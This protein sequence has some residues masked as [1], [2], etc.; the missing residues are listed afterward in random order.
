M[1]R[2][3]WETLQSQ[4]IGEEKIMSYLELKELRRHIDDAITMTYGAMT[5]GP[6]RDFII[7]ELKTALRMIAEAMKE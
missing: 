3:N 4:I 6:C 1:A 5:K 2:H 7:S